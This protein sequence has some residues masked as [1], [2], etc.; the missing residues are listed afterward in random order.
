MRALQRAMTAF[1]FA[2]KALRQVMRANIFLPPRLRGGQGWGSSGTRLVF[3]D[4]ITPNNSKNPPFPRQ[5]PFSE[6]PKVFSDLFRV[7]S[8]LFRVFNMA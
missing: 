1:R 2:P 7:F 6:H 3:H 4:A 5:I 8:N